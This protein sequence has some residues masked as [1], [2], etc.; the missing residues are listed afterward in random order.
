MER[1]LVSYR[2]TAEDRETKASIGLY[3][4]EN[5]T[6]YKLTLVSRTCPE[7]DYNL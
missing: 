1:K 3:F 6:F 7:G 4:V 2:L 5:S